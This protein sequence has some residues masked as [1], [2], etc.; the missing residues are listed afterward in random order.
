MNWKTGFF[1]IYI[2]IFFFL[3][4]FSVRLIFFGATQH[5]MLCNIWQHWIATT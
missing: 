4:Y 1:Y 2:Y 3:V 5:Q